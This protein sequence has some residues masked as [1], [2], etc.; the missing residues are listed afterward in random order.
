MTDFVRHDPR[1]GVR[2]GSNNYG[3]S[4]LGALGPVLEGDDWPG[5][6]ATPL[7]R[8]PN[9]IQRAIRAAAARAPAVRRATRSVRVGNLGP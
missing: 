7:S 3:L 8:P 9:S 6:A 4:D 1:P 5:T 2:A